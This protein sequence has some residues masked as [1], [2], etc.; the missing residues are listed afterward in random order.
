MYD[1]RRLQDCIIHARNGV[2]VHAER[3]GQAEQR[4]CCRGYYADVPCMGG[5]YIF[6]AW[7]V[8]FGVTAFEGA[9]RNC[10]GLRKQRGE[11]AGAGDNLR[12][13]LV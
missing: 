4:P 2:C 7:A 5:R 13:I 3:Q 1:G 6:Q 8:E 9:G 10:C 11:K 12:A